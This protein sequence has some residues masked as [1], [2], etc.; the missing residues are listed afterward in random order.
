MVA[1]A[2]YKGR[3]DWEHIIR[4]VGVP[5]TSFANPLPLSTDGEK[6]SSDSDSDVDK[7]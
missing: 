1:L 2:S 5:G 3:P 6:E 4:L 7:L